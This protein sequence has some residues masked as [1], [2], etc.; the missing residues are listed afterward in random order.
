MDG[1]IW[2]DVLPYPNTMPVLSRDG[3]GGIW[4]DVLPYPNTIA[5]SVGDL[6]GEV[7]RG[8]FPGNSCNISITF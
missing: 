8:S 7:F 2:M 4:M 3:Y 6:Y 5:G 1:G